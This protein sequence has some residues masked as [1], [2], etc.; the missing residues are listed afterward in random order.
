MTAQEA[1]KRV[2]DD[3]VYCSRIIEQWCGDDINKVW[4]L[5]EWGA[6]K[7]KAWMPLPEPWKGDEE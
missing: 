5:E 4:W 3:D 1:I 6:V 7:V 2:E